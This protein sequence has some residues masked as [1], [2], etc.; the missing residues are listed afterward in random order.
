[1]F[2]KN[3]ILQ[4]YKSQL[5]ETL[6]EKKNFHFTVCSEICIVSYVRF[7]LWK[8]RPVAV[9]INGFDIFPLIGSERTIWT[10]SRQEA[11][12]YSIR[13]LVAQ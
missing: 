11:L 12:S 7:V 1:M 10:A 8:V 6:L 4:L 5:K 2:L 9:G 3:V 13:N